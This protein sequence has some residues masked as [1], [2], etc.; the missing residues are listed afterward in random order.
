M[1]K[2]ESI[3]FCFMKYWNLD[4]EQIHK[5]KILKHIKQKPQYS[6]ADFLPESPKEFLP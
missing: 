5:K 6:V 4:E 2:K 1:I 3:L